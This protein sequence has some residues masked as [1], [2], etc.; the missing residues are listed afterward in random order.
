MKPL[1]WSRIAL[2]A[3]F[4][5]RTTP[6]L[7]LLHLP[8]ASDAWPLLGWPSEHWAGSA[9][10]HLPPAIAA[11]AC[12]ARTIA[13]I[14]FTL[15]IATSISGLA[16]GT[17]GY[18]VMLQHPFGLPFTLHL[19]F[20]GTII[21]AFAD[22]GAALALRPEPPRATFVEPSAR[23]VFSRFD[24][25]SGRASASSVSIGWMVEPW[26]SSVPT[27]LFTGGPIERSWL[28]RRCV[29]PVP[30]AWWSSSFRFPGSC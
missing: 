29:R 27:A 24:L 17:L 22:A 26:R 21:L 6:L 19:L 20:Q 3:L 2:G 25:I 9:W 4:L 23:P 12:V 18:L 7:D 14:L 15:G 10:F 11:V 5:F 30:S 8:F 1:A 28:A 16:A 13:A